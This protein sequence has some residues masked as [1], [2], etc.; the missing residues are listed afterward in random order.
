LNESIICKFTKII[1]KTILLEKAICLWNVAT[2]KC[3]QY[4]RIM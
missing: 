3:Y 4:Q 1:Y 2:I